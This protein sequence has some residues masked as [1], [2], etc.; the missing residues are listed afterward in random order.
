MRSFVGG[1]FSGRELSG[2]SVSYP[3]NKLLG[4]CLKTTHYVHPK[5]QHVEFTFSLEMRVLIR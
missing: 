5:T 3:S 4:K 2:T 1:T